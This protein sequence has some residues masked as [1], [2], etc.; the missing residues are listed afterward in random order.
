MPTE[1]LPIKSEK[2]RAKA[3]RWV[4]KV[5]L[6]WTLIF[7]PPLRKPKQNDKMWAMLD[8]IALQ[9]EYWGKKRTSD[10]W[11]DI[12]TGSLRGQE[13]VPNLENNGFIAFGRRTSEMGD[14]EM[15]DLLQL[16]ETWG[17]QNGIVFS[18]VPFESGGGPS[19]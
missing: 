3:Q 13:M 1:K 2:D 18:D 12:F 5:P 10:E 7:R 14:D 11:K 15:S 8:D 6:G 4:A 17:A 16:I 19:E 9:K